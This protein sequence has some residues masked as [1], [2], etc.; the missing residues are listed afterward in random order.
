MKRHQ[1]SLFTLGGILLV[2]VGL[3][4]SCQAYRPTGA[5]K[6][7]TLGNPVREEKTGFAVSKYTDVQS[8]SVC[9]KELILTTVGGEVVT[10]PYLPVKEMP[11]PMNGLEL[12]SLDVPFGQYTKIS[13]ELADSCGS[14]RSVLIRNSQGTFT[15]NANISLKFSGNEFVGT[16]AHKIVLNIKTLTANLSEVSS[17][18]NVA[19][20]AEGSS[21]NYHSLTCGIQSDINQVAFCEPFDQASP[22]VSRSGQLNSSVWNV[23]RRGMNNQ[24]QGAL[25]TWLSSTLNACGTL[26][27]AQAGSDL[28]ICN[29]QL[30][31][32]VRDPGSYLSLKMSPNQP[33]DFAG[34]TGTI[35]LDVTNDTSGSTGV[36]P[37]IWI[38]DQASPGYQQFFSNPTNPR[39]GVMLRLSASIQPFIGANFPGCPT[40]GNERWM[41]DAAVLTKNYAPSNINVVGLGCVTKS[42]GP[43]GGMNHIEL[44]VSQ[45]QI[46]VWATD[47]GSPILKKIAMIQNL[48]LP[49]TRGY[50]TLSDTHNA[51]GAGPRPDHASHT[52]AWDNIA[53]DGPVIARD[54]AFNV[55][56]NNEVRGAGEV[57]LGWETSAAAP[58]QL[59]T[60]PLSAN[61]I[62]AAR[63]SGKSP[64]LTFNAFMWN[65]PV[66]QIQYSVNGTVLTG[67]LPVPPA[68]YETYSVDFAVPVS[69]L[70][71]GP[72]RVSIWADG[73][74][75]LSN[76]D[77]RLPGAGQ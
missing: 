65:V 1:R 40:D 71:P 16:A 8:L 62:A 6:T 25:G 3:F 74:L 43:N 41:V 55:L 67:T 72:Q 22:V 68:S 69:A 9:I 24:G 10:V 23:S 47:A 4:N 60:L 64:V 26:Q 12:G 19:M 35:A 14:G 36:W 11:I 20:V 38:T 33:F 51:A 29:G 48:N 73:V 52:F 32:S 15:S 53:F 58:A 49:F 17:N 18:S 77:I 44:R 28:V 54:L 76:I 31:E 45:N 7:S 42:S 34:R 57:N 56:D 30:R 61:D 21:D 75:I 2:T 13:L 50:L 5:G 63:A 59:D 46:D 66:T 37:E 27:A 39:N 70:Q